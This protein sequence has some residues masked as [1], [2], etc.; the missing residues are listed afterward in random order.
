MKLVTMIDYGHWTLPVGITEIPS[1]TIGFIYCITDNTG[2]K[3]VGKKLLEF[4]KSRPPL[5]G[6]KNK[7]RYKVESDWK[8]YT[9]SSPILNE[10]IERNG[11]NEFKFEIISFQPSKMLLSY[12]ETKELIDRNAI[13]DATYY[14]EVLNCRFRN[15]KS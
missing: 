9:G 13:F 1:N 11:K 15:K 3:Y 10:Y 7:R 6:N 2:K 4:K 12:Y 5:K 14:N 8:T